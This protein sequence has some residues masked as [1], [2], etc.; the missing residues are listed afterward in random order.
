MEKPKRMSPDG[1]PDPRTI[2][3]AILGFAVAVW[4]LGFTGIF[5]TLISLAVTALIVLFLLGPFIG[6]YPRPEVRR[7]HFGEP[8]GNATAAAIDLTLAV[9]R[10]T[11][12]A[13]DDPERLIDADVASLGNVTFEATGET[14]KRVTLRQSGRG[15]TLASFNPLVWIGSHRDL[16]WDVRL[17]TSIPLDLNVRSAAGEARLDLSR[18][19]LSRLRLQCAVGA[20]RVTLPAGPRYQAVIGGGA[21][22]TEI[23]IAPGAD[24]EAQI[25]GG[26]GETRL[27]VGQG[28][29]LNARI[30]GGV[31]ELIVSLP[32][33]APA[34]IVASVTVGDLKLPPR[35]VSLSSENRMVGGAGTWQTANF[36]DGDPQIVIEYSGAVGSL[37]IR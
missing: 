5:S 2:W 4:L 35:F 25:D 16:N 21:G 36:S 27:I 8:L 23:E 30:R 34:R 17:S 11:V 22:E 37:T 3:I 18:L 9:G 13:L 10:A 15:L 1:S 32:P 6:L 33:E 19:R 20:Q 14:E 31:G 28:T 7:E 29:A 12:A 24:I 26:V